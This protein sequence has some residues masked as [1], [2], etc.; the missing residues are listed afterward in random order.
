MRTTKRTERPVAPWGLPLGAILPGALPRTPGTG[1]H[2]VEV[3][4]HPPPEVPAGEL[5]GGDDARGVAGPAP[6]A[7]RL[8]VDARDAADGVHDLQHGHAVAAADVVDRLA[9]IPR[10]AAGGGRPGGAGEGAL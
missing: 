5:A 7:L 6:L 9:R 8:E 10:R 4:P 1:D 3:V 2:L